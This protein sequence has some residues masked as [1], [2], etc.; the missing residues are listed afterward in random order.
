MFAFTQPSCKK[1]VW[2]HDT[3]YKLLVH[4]PN[5]PPCRHWLRTGR[6]PSLEAELCAFAH[7][8]E[9]KSKE[10][11]LGRK[12]GGNRVKVRNTFRVSAFRNWLMETYGLELLLNGTVIDVAGGIGTLSWELKNCVGVKALLIEPRPTALG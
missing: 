9:E 7:L 12:W 3:C 1:L 11:G 8:E 5:P 10:Q 4:P 6:C 2:G